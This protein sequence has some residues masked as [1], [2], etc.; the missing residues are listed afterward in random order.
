MSG[1]GKMK[2]RGGQQQ[3]WETDTTSD[4]R[5]D[6][7]HLPELPHELVHHIVGLLLEMK[8]MRRERG[9]VSSGSTAISGERSARRG[10]RVKKGEKKKRK[11]EKKKRKKEKKK[12]PPPPPPPSPPSRA[13]CWMDDPGPSPRR[14]AHLARDG[15]GT[16]H[17][18][19]GDDPLVGL[20]AL[21][22]FF[23]I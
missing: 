7:T 1:E 20:L 9:T 16:V 14:I 13:V 3:Q 15:E 18:E 2:G 8:M 5:G 19:Q 11:K 10:G 12:T 6:T 22:H 23:F 4:H 17:I 21:R